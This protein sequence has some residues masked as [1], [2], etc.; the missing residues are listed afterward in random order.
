MPKLT[1]KRTDLF[2]WSVDQPPSKKPRKTV[3]LID[4][5]IT[6]NY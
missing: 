3:E 2:E 6:Y 5:N 4:W 1:K